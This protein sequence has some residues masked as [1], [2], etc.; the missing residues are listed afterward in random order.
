MKILTGLF[1]SLLIISVA[2]TQIDYSH[3]QDGTSGITSGYGAWGPYD[4]IHE[5]EIV[6]S[7]K[8]KINFYRPDMSPTP[9]PA[10]FFINGWG[11]EAYTY[12]YLFHFLA[13]QG[14]TVTSIYNENPGNIA[15][16]YQNALDMILQAARS[17]FPAWIDTT[18]TGLMGHSYGGGATIWLGK[19]LFA[20]PHD[21]GTNGRFI[22]MTA[23]WYSLLVTENDLQNYP[24]GV[25][26]VIEISNDDL[27]AS[28]NGNYNTDE[29]AVRAVFELINI[30]DSEKDFIRVYSDPQHTYNYDGN[31]DGTDE[32]YYYKADHYI[33]YANVFNDIGEFQPYDALDV[34]ALNR[35]IHALA[36]YT[37]HRDI[38]AKNVALGNNAP[39]QT[40]MGFLPD[41]LVTD[42]PVITRPESVFEYKCSDTWQDF[43]TGQNT[44]FL[45]NACADSDQDGIID[46]LEVNAVTRYKHV[47]NIFPNPA[48]EFLYFS[49]PSPKHI[50]IYDVSGKKLLEQTR[51][52][53]VLNVS[54]LPE[55]FYILQ[56]RQENNAFNLR[57]FV[58]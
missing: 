51:V 21:W 19:H 57:F 45:Q 28:G 50:R 46:L 25:K 11:R 33:S 48:H 39:Q 7:G 15:S 23:P 12:E 53:E 58:N 2:R 6:V 18:R 24:S 40:D 10:L 54:S 5:Q 8:G 37:F 49:D 34:Y 41:L 9:L 31:N 17:E 27:H 35:I 4:V 52:K 56:I 14:Y 47:M 22:F 20:P 1:A 38:S 32:T 44:W 3:L 13:S 16:S 30:P 43:E 26:L 42:Y 55:G 29:R 36:E